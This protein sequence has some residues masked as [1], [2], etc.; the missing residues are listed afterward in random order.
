MRTMHGA[1]QPVNS[2]PE[3]SAPDTKRYYRIQ[4]RSERFAHRPYEERMSSRQVSGSTQRHQCEC[5]TVA[6]N[7][8][9][10]DIKVSGI[11]DE[12]ATTFSQARAH[13]MQPS[14]CYLGSEVSSSAEVNQKVQL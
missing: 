2:R 7:F 1:A 8:L 5:R 4:S 14:R 3:N 9:C 13:V 11:K 10:I 6:Q 12:F